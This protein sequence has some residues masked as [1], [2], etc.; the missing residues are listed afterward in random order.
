MSGIKCLEREGFNIEENDKIE[1]SM[2]KPLVFRCGDI[3][4]DN[5]LFFEKVAD[6]YFENFIPDTTTKEF[7]TG[8]V[9]IA[10][11]FANELFRK[12]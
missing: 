7:D 1:F 5:T 3:M 9:L 2:N 11:G 10:E 8:D 6:N 4:Y 12:L